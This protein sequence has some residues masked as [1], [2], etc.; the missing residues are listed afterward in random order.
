MIGWAAG[1]CGQD[2][3]IRRECDAAGQRDYTG[4]LNDS[5]VLWFACVQYG[6]S[7]VCWINAD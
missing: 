3:A 5:S 4:S 6:S 2:C 7:L 1:S